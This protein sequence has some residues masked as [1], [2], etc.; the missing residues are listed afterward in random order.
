MMGPST[1][2]ATW[3][4]DIHAVTSVPDPIAPVPLSP[5]SPGGL[6]FT[7]A[8]PPAEGQLLGARAALALDVELLT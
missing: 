6:T 1:C 5:D 7:I 2:R 8:L 4:V 3:E